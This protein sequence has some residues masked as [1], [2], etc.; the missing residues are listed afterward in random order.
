MVRGLMFVFVMWILVSIGI[1]VFGHLTRNEK[2]SVVKSLT[3]GAITAAV[4]GVIVAGIVT[5]F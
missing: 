2:R 4:T 3:Y 1:Y 5:I